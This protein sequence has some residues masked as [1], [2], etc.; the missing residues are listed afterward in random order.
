LLRSH[1]AAYCRRWQEHDYDPLAIARG[2]DTEFICGLTYFLLITNVG[3]MPPPAVTLSSSFEDKRVNA[4]PT[5]PLKSRGSRSTSCS[6]NR[7][8]S[9][10][11]SAGKV[12]RAV[13]TRSCTR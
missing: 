2:T 5:L 3:T 4:D 11:V 1:G 9:S 12:S 8:V 13:G 10:G 7:I 6:T